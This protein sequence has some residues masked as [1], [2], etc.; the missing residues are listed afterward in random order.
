MA[1]SLQVPGGGFGWEL[2]A[3]QV[4]PLGIVCTVP[5]AHYTFKSLQ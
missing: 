4:Y 3:D 2:L 5:R 1:L